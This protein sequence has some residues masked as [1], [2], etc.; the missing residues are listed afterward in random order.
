MAKDVI[1]RFK[2]ET[3]Q[4]D[5]AIKNAAKGLTEYSRTAANAGKDFDK[6]TKSNVEAAR[7]LGTMATSSTKAKDKVKELV[8]A[9]NEAAKAYNELSKEQQQ[10]DWAKALAASLTQ[11]QQRIRDTKAEMQSM[12][13]AIDD[14][15][16]KSSGIFGEGGL[17]GMLQVAGGNLMAQGITKLG[18]EIGDTIQQ[19]IELARAGEGVRIAFERLNQPGLL[20]KLKEATHGTVSE[21]ELM[22]Q[23]IKFENFKL[24]LEDLATYLAFAQQK[25]KDT[26]ESV[27]YMVNSITTGLG[28]QS[29]Q[30]LDNLGISAAELTKRMNEG[31]DMTKA[32]ADIIR[33]EMA[34]AGD[35]VET[36]ADRAARAAADA[37]NQME[38]LGREAMP[39]AEQWAQAWNTIKMGGVDLL[40]TVFG[41]LARSAAQIQ[42]I[43]NGGGF[44]F[45]A[46]IPNLADGPAPSP[47]RQPGNDHKVQ[48]PG[49]YVVV[50]D[51]NTG[52]VIGGQH[53]DNLQD[54]NSIKDW[55][56]TLFKTPKTPKATKT[57]KTEEQ[58]NNDKINK[59]T[60]EYI[61]AS[62]DRRKAIEAEIK[63]LQKR[64]EEIKKLTDI[65]QGKIA[66][67]GSLK[68]LNDELKEL[69]NE[70]QKLT[71]PIAIEIQDQAIKDVQDEID[72]LN[73]KKV[74]IDVE[75]NMP[76]LTAGEA[77]E[78]EVRIK[79]AEHNMDA[80]MQTL[81]TLLETQIKNGIEDIEIPSDLLIQQIMGEGLNIPDKY[82]EDLQKQI[83]EKLKEMG[84]DQIDIDFNTGK[85]K[86]KKKDKERDT[87]KDSRQLVGGLN[88]VA[89]GL[90][91]M[92]IELPKEVNEVMG[93][94]NGLM[95]VIEGLN[96]IISIGQIGA[97]TANTVA[98][99]AL[100]AAIS[101]NTAV[102]LIPFFSNGGI[103]P[104][105]AGGRLI[106]GNNMSGDNIFAGGAWV[107]SGELVLNKAEQGNLASQLQDNEMQSAGGGIP[108]VMGEQIIL[109]ANNHLKRSGQGE[110]V[111]TG[112]LK[113]MGV[114]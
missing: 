68:A 106:G 53:F 62:D 67:E 92:G 17:T 98:L 105:A 18:A 111:T 56:K 80:D 54:T 101:T 87:L 112:M 10:S 19:S 50:T 13:D 11:L 90:Q 31:A 113:R 16:S 34:K 99:G 21:V 97:I 7:A 44:K 102:S 72:R 33:E 61:K 82:W 55:Q 43:L 69:Q 57:E 14:V 60:Q 49:G 9:Y 63:T 25:A 48:A 96:S 5:S 107:N 88:A 93:F 84:I 22:K 42:Q 65:A 30:I 26:G 94:V 8:G 58:L 64:N 109:G 1:T 20:D 28:R 95:N 23:A 39:V 77:L 78:Q 6:F 51:K 47:T 114:M 75:A 100:T 79:L 32:V 81:R 110:I 3:T 41:P 91:Q 46:G 2:L 29:K 35:Y 4:Y 74:T 15:K 103:V 36:A 85:S 76:Q 89:S 59:L 27:D 104:K 38:D 108:Y 45:R 86:D 37:Q 52:A 66:P 40:N 70:R 73:G 24:P 83:N 12:G 71:D